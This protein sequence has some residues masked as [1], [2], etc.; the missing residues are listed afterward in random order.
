MEVQK[1]AKKAWQAR[2]GISSK[3]AIEVLRKVVNNGIRFKEA[4]DLQKYMKLGIFLKNSK[5]SK[6]SIKN[7]EQIVEEAEKYPELIEQEELVVMKSRLE[8]FKKIEAKIMRCVS[9]IRS[10]GDLKDR[11][12]K[13]ILQ[14]IK[15]YKMSTKHQN[16]L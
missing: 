9:S 7:I 12:I 8:I 5:S 13:P 1:N 3:N 11:E 2:K 10:L 14:E 16:T 6:S 15:K 4:E